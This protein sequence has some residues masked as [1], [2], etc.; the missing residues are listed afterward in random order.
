VQFSGLASFFGGDS[1]LQKGLRANKVR[2]VTELL[3]EDST[4]KFNGVYYFNTD[5]RTIELVTPYGT[6]F[7]RM[8]FEYAKNGITTRQTRYD[9]EDT[10]KINTWSMLTLDV[11]GRILKDE[12][13]EMREGKVY[14]SKNYEIIYGQGKKSDRMVASK[15][16]RDN[17]LEST[18]VMRDTIIGKD[19][20]GI[21]YETSPEGVDRKGRSFAKKTLS[22][23]YRTEGFEYHVQIEYFVFG[24][25]ESAQKVTTY[26]TQFNENGRV[27]EDGEIDY[28]EAY[29]DFMQEHPE[30]FNPSYISPLF[31]KAVLAKKIKGQK[32][33][34]NRYS[35]NSKGLVTEYIVSQAESRPESGYEY[36]YQIK[37][38]DKDQ[39]VEQI[40]FSH[41]EKIGDQKLWYNEKG[42]IIR[43]VQSYSSVDNQESDHAAAANETQ[44][45]ESKLNTTKEYLYTYTY[46]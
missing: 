44:T 2:S 41:G 46:F 28:D 31:I 12:R 17:K 27:V 26:Y 30:D 43:M 40:T 20:F 33:P 34:E 35:Y 32:K 39:L 22:H 10:S 29:T 3:K 4:K 13:G 14:I 25:K 37:Y 36:V 5:A 42:L 16:Y 24:G 23:F 38:N 8:K 7:N 11:K 9:Y 6:G 21:S 18:T 19:T 15:R 1:L 45:A